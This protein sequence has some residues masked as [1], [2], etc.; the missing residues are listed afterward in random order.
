MNN[1]IKYI[2]DVNI[3]LVV[4][5][6][7]FLIISFLFFNKKGYNTRIKD[8][9][10]ISYTLIN[11]FLFSYLNSIFQGVF[12]LKYLSTK[13]YLITVL[14]T[15]FIFLYT[16]NKKVKLIY[17][18]ANYLTTILTSIILLVNLY[19]VISNKLKLFNI[20]PINKAILLMNISCIIFFVY[21]TIL[22]ISYIIYNTKKI[23]L[24]SKRINELSKF[25]KIKQR[26]EL[27]LPPIKLNKIVN[28]KKEKK[29]KIPS[30]KNS[31]KLEESVLP[32][33]KEISLEQLLNY[34]VGDNFYINGIDCSIIFC[35]SNKENIVKNYKILSTDI[36]AKLVNGYTLEENIMIKNICTKLNVNNLSSIDINNFTIL[37]L[38]SVDEYMFLKKIFNEN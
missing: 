31:V 36:T 32:N 14:I 38:I 33:N 2:A 26:K 6:I 1:L 29:F 30:K 17:K 20:I 21:L 22:S 16:F 11:L 19:I 35:D 18:L 7:L 13:L 5:D 28:S 4:L 34:K 23:A 25:S 3:L 8:L 37:N 10:V 9:F 24:S 12:T 27:K 15:L